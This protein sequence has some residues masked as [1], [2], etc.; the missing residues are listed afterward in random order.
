MRKRC[1]IC[2]RVRHCRLPERAVREFI[3]IKGFTKMSSFLYVFIGGGA[4][5]VVRYGIGLLTQQ[6]AER[7]PIATFLSNAGA[8]LILGWVMATAARG[9]MDDRMRLLLATGFCG[10]FSTFSTFTAESWQLWHRGDTAA[11]LVNLL[12][13]PAVCW[14]CFLAGFRGL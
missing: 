4:G 5:A 8:C 11:L 2:P 6:W 12:F 1:Y 10:G 9:E 13:H 3:L 7:F 14:I